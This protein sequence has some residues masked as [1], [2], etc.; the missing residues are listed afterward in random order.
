MSAKL[1]LV[2]ALLGLAVP[3]GIN[4]SFSQLRGQEPPAC[5]HQICM[6]NCA[7]TCYEDCAFANGWQCAGGAGWCISVQCPL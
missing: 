5:E 6:R 2:A 7:P 3:V 4:A 1:R